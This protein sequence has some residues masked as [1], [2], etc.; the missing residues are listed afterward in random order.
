[1]RNRFLKQESIDFIINQLQDNPRGLREQAR[2]AGL[3]SAYLWRILRRKV[4][5]SPYALDRLVKV[6]KLSPSDVLR[7]SGRLNSEDAVISTEEAETLKQIAEAQVLDDDGISVLRGILERVYGKDPRIR[8]LPGTP[9]WAI[10]TIAAWFLSTFEQMNSPVAPPIQ[11]EDL[12]EFSGLSLIMDDIA[13]LGVH[14]E[15]EVNMHEGYIL[16]RRLV[17]NIGRQHFS[18]AHELGHFILCHIDKEGQST[19][20]RNCKER[21]ANRFAAAILMPP[22]LVQQQIALRRCD[23]LNP[24]DRY[25]L[26]RDFEVSV[27]AMENALLSMRIVDKGNLRD[28]RLSVRWRASGALTYYGR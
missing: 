19:G 27:A 8:V 22:K 23:I 16:T 7:G 10:E 12:V 3:D 24:V 9:S 25:Q 1:M 21:D 15:A 26:A 5:P 18:I 17:N 13:F 11:I 6:L 2:L 14:E 20:E 28:S 4:V